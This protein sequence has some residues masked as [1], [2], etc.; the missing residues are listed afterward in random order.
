MEQGEIATRPFWAARNGPVATRAADAGAATPV[1]AVVGSVHLDQCAALLV[2]EYGKCWFERGAVS[3]HFRNATSE[4]DRVQA[5]CGI[6]RERQQVAVWLRR[7]DGLQVASGTASLGDHSASALRA[8]D[9]RPSAPADL[10]ILRRVRVGETLGE[11]RH[12]LDGNRQLERYR[13]GTISDPLS[14]YQGPSP[15]GAP[16]AAPSTAVGM[17]W[18]VPLPGLRDAVGEGVGVFGAIEVAHHAGPLLLGETYRI[19]AEVVAVSESPRTESLWLDSFAWRG[20]EL[21]ASQRMMLR[22]MK[23]SSPLYQGQ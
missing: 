17:L 2:E 6:P 5:A 10:R 4:G 19:T 23:A 3:V 14:W 9:L 20:G 7:E 16:V 11:W 8:C 13:A 18:G 21:V 15:W 12:E 22:F 1:A